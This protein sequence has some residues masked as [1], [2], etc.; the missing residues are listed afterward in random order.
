VAGIS[1]VSEEALHRHFQYKTEN[2]FKK[3]PSES[4]LVMH[5]Q[6]EIKRENGREIMKRK[7]YA[8]KLPLRIL[9]YGICFTGKNAFIFRVIMS[10]INLTLNM[11]A[12]LGLL[13][14]NYEGSIFS[15]LPSL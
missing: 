11:K 15:A 5:F 8:R 14:P 9:F 7:I 4:G 13:Y 1:H 2:L 6:N 12:I 10:L 3:V